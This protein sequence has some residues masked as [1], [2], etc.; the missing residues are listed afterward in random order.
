MKAALAVQ[1]VLSDVAHPYSPLIRDSSGNLYGT[2]SE[3]GAHNKGTV[4][5]LAPSGMFTVLHSFS[6]PDGAT[7]LSG[8]IRNAAGTLH[9]TAS[10]GGTHGHRTVYRIGF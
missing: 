9:L 6:G 8:L 5:K 10:T 1:G 7:P 3:G 4:F 2:K